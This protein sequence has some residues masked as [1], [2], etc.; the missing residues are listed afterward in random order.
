MQVFK[1]FLDAKGEELSLT[2][3]FLPYYALPYIS[4]PQEHTSFRHLF[5]QEW[6]TDMRQ[7]LVQYLQKQSSQKQPP[8]LY[9]L[10]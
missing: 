7:Y 3:E 2:A 8:L 9:K 4:N 5:S 1:S 10:F 6:V